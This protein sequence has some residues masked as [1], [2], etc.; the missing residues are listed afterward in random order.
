MVATCSLQVLTDIMNSLFSIDSTPDSLKAGVLTP[1]YKRK[2][3]STDAKNYMRITIL[4]VI[5]KILETVIKNQI[6][7]IIEHHQSKLRRGFTRNASPMNCSLILEEA[8]REQCEKCQPLC[9]AFLGAKSAF[10][11]V[12]HDSLM[13]KLYHIGIEGTPWLLIR[14]LHQ[15]ATAAVKWDGAVSEPFSVRQGV[16]QG[17]ILSTD[18]YK[19]YLDGCLRR[20][21]EVRGGYHIGEICCAAP[22]C[23]D[24]VAAISNTLGVLQSMVS[25]A[26]DYSEMELYLIQPEKSVILP[27]NSNFRG[28]QTGDIAINI[29][30]K[31]MPFVSESIHMGILR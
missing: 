6:Q 26:V 31:P 21:A 24:D 20:L 15:D 18:L 27:G 28:C 14:S 7:P 2:G 5:T 1:V 12:C 11:V 4:P 23:A 9:V 25:S 10:D 3:L 8:M 30:R 16:R 13:R 19:V 29:G 22:T 17:G